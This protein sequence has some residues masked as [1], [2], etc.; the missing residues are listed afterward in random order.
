MRLPSAMHTDGDSEHPPLRVLVVDDCKMIQKVLGRFLK[1]QKCIVTSAEN[2][3]I[4]FEKLSLCDTVIPYDVVFMDFLMPVMDGLESLK[5]YHSWQQDREC[6]K[7]F[8]IGF[9]ATAHSQEQDDAFGEY[10]CLL[11][12]CFCKYIPS[13]WNH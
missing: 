2:G 9:S 13:M 1:S 8:V 4:G 7:P 6:D 3:L 12:D 5:A 11:Y 10:V